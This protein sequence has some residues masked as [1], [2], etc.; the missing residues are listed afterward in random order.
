MSG[1]RVIGRS[2]R[3]KLRHYEGTMTE[4]ERCRLHAFEEEHKIKCGCE[5]IE[6]EMSRASDNGRKTDATCPVWG[7]KKRHH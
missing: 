1:S 4:T 7:E 6:V 2:L 3:R 5:I